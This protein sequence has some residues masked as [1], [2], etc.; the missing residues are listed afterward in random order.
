MPN[1]DIWD[2]L[3]PETNEYQDPRRAETDIPEDFEYFDE[4]EETRALAREESFSPHKGLGAGTKA[5][6]G[7]CIFLLALLLLFQLF[8]IR[9]IKIVGLNRISKEE[10]LRNAGLESQKSKFFFSV[11][12]ENVKEGINHNRYLKFMDME[13]ILPN[14]LVI[15]VKERVPCAY[16]SYLGIGYLIADDGMILEKV[17]SSFQNQSYPCISG[18]SLKE[19]LKP[20]MIPQSTR[21]GQMN[22]LTAMLQELTGDGYLSK[23]SAINIADPSSIYFSVKS[24]FLVHIGKIDMLN[25]KLVTVEAVIQILE[26]NNVKSGLLEATIPGAVTY[27]PENP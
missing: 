26:Q 2:S 11:K 5:V 6:I 22:A 7:I 9:N 21:P 20:G 3:P 1:D 4:E 24:G 17:K 27:R 23:I 18:L 19:N 16:F 8:L 12:S 14:T 10:A 25:A 13:K 15:N